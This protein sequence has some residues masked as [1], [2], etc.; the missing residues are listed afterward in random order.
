MTRKA[1]YRNLSNYEA[2]RVLLKRHGFVSLDCGAMSWQ[3]QRQAFS[4]AEVVIGVMGAAMTN[5]IFCP[6][7]TRVGYL[8]PSGWIEPFFWDLAATLKHPYAVAFGKGRD[9]SL[10]AHE[11]DFELSPI[12]LEHLVN[13]ATA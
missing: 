9:L 5:T 4:A 11:R 7:G 6:Q 1:H 3:E 2:L 10:P 8:A 12:D 13:W